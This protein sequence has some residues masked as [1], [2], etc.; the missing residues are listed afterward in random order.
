VA[1][2][3]RESETAAVRFV[4]QYRLP[5]H[6]REDVRQDLLLD[7]LQRIKAFDPHRGSFGA[8]VGAIVGHRV[9]RLAKKICRERALQTALSESCGL[10][11]SEPTADHKLLVPEGIEVGAQPSEQFRR[12]EFR[13]D[14]ERSLRLLDPDDVAL[15][16]QLAEYAPTEICRSANMSRAGVYRR[17]KAI[18]MHMLTTGL[19]AAACAQNEALK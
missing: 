11:L 8:F 16:L 10:A 17:I 2:L 13:L 3:L 5:A 14:L 1:L 12:T 7:A 6:E 19:V 15:C 4:Y 18:R 9:A